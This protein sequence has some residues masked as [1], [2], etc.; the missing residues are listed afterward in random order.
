MTHDSGQALRSYVRDG[1]HPYTILDESVMVPG[2][3]C[4][5]VAVQRLA[6]NHLK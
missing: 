4:L 6:L 2:F 5:E 3:A 1:E